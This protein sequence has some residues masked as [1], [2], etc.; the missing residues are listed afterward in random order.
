[1][2]DISVKCSGLRA[3]ADDFNECA[4]LL[5]NASHDVENIINT[6]H[7]PANSL[8]S[9][10]RSL[11]ADKNSIT[12]QRISSV[13]M[14]V[15]AKQ[16]ATLYEN[17]ELG[18]AGKNNIFGNITENPHKENY[19]KDNIHIGLVP[20]MMKYLYPTCYII[21]NFFK[22]YDEIPAE[23][24]IKYKNTLNIKYFENS[25]DTDA[26]NNAV[27]R[28]A[29]KLKAY[30]DKH[31]KELID[32]KGFIERDKDG[33]LKIREFSDNEKKNYKKNK[34]S[35]DL[36]IAS[37]Q[38]SC[39]KSLVSGD[40]VKIGNVNADRQLYITN[41]SLGASAGVGFSALSLE[42]RGQIGN[43]YFNLHLKGNAKVLEGELKGEL[44][45]GL[46]DKD[47]RINPSAYIGGSA[48]LNAVKAE[49]KGG[50]TIAGTDIDVTGGATVGLGA[51]AVFGVKN[52][53]I[54]ADIGASVG[55][56]FSVKLDIDTSRTIDYIV[57][58]ADKIKDAA[59]DTVSS[60]WRKSKS[61][62]DKIW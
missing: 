50:A 19:I 7:L 59:T 21:Y 40:V 35:K 12:N 47:G 18:I 27:N 42:K 51:H 31:K 30:N 61:I 10:K 62:W 6:L 41:R 9:I 54:T 2:A 56:G 55:L 28:C 60:L 5:A 32:T 58:N 38:D 14:A 11:R 46:R 43:D 13:R 48:E 52:G 16:A 33:K 25:D 36:T 45:A 22:K 24:K 44:S 57:D 26:K 34:L 53:K 4:N 3:V 29:N 1:M 20:G 23:E 37:V 8:N 15:A 39:S 17:A 49:V